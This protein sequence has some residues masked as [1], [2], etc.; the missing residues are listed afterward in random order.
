VTTL[1]RTPVKLHGA[2]LHPT[3]FVGYENVP[4]G[5]A[6]DLAGADL[7]HG[8]E[9]CGASSHVDTSRFVSLAVVDVTDCARAFLLVTKR[10]DSIELGEATRCN[11]SAEV[12]W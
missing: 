4:R 7:L 5:G 2:A 8:S 10:L 6:T 12:H 11:D 9:D 1:L 3:I